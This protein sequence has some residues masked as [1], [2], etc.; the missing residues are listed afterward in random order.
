MNCKFMKIIYNFPKIGKG[1]I[2]LKMVIQVQFRG[3]RFELD[4]GEIR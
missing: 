3:I 1:G 2:K 4:H